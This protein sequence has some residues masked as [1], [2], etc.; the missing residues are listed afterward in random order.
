LSLDGTEVA[1]KWPEL[2]LGVTFGSYLCS[3]SS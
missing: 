1:W 2:Y 3:G